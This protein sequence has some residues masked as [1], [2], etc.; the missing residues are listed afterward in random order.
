MTYESPMTTVKIKLEEGTEKSDFS[1]IE[2]IQVFKDSL[3][4]ELIFSDSTDKGLSYTYNIVRTDPEIG[5]VPL[6]DGNIV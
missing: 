4:G 1:G 3:E 2:E 6:A 5:E